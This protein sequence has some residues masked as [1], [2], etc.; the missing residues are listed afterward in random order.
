MI[1]LAPYTRLLQAPELRFLFGASLIGR[2]PIGMT[3]LAILLLVQQASASFAAGGVV[4]G[5]YI[6]GLACV[7]PLLGRLID[8]RGPSVVLF[9]SA[10][11]FPASLAALV[12]AV[13]AGSG[14]LMV[15]LW[16]WIA[17]A[18]FPP[19]TVCI[20]TYLRQ[21]LNDDADL[22]TAYSLDSALIE[23]MFIAGPLLVAGLAA[24]A[25]PSAAVALAAACAA[26]GALLFS[27]STA[28][29]TWRIETTRNATLLGPLATH[30][31][32][33]LIAIVGCYSLAFGLTEIGVVASAAEIGRPALAGVY[34][35]VMSA[36]SALGGLAYGS[37]A[38]GVP[39]LRQFA[40][41][42]GIM[43]IG[44]FIL[45]APWSSLAF[46]V[47]CFFAGI[48][49]APALIIQSMLIAKTARAEH[50]TEAFTWS[51][52]ALLAGVGL[53]MAAGGGLV[54]S[55]QS[56]AALAASGVSSVLAAL[57]AWW[58]ADR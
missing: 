36:G 34:L 6:A 51:T 11:L 46:L 41:T 30:S 28:L 14:I 4:T 8:R 37:R 35:G 17:G 50:T 44:L 43:G 42:L 29:R 23:L 15:L 58:L 39:L 56:S 53:G 49:M 47:L 26:I 9:V 2:L 3:G 40:V 16:A 27:R 52:T 32:L 22:S 25:S 7:A 24:L 33:P 57:L 18:A 20:R 54:E 5:C 10:L 19:I 55:W 12:A 13:R 31:F 48:V 21:H 38:W 45:A 1:S